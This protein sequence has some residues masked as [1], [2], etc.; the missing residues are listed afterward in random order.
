[1]QFSIFY[2]SLSSGENVF[3][4]KVFLPRLFSYFRDPTFL[5]IKLIK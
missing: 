2:F 3:Y 5:F 1:M 4:I